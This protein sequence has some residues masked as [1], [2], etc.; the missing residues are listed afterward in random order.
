MTNLICQ[1]N[2]PM[3]EAKYFSL[4]FALLFT[5]EITVANCRLLSDYNMEIDINECTR[6]NKLQKFSDF[7]ECF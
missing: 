4:Y 5:V 2:V 3:N 7:T 6:A 1:I